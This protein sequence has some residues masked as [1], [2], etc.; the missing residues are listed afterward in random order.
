MWKYNHFM[1]T[2]NSLFWKF[3]TSF[4]QLNQFYDHKVPE[5]FELNKLEI[6]FRKFHFS[7][8]TWPSIIPHESKTLKKFKYHRHHSINS[9]IKYRT[10]Y[11]L[12]VDNYVK[13][14]TNSVPNK[15]FSSTSVFYHFK[16][17]FKIALI[18]LETIYLF[19]FLNI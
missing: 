3:S 13:Y 15:K 9:F 12:L 4:V 7:D 18:M 1:Y 5:I 10:K 8:K 14:P 6:N 16:K 11:H 19:L 17:S 2:Y